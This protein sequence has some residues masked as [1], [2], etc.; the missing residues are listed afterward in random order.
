[1]NFLVSIS[2]IAFIL[3]F[4]A[5]DL[6]S[7]L[8]EN[9]TQ[10]PEILR[11]GNEQ[12]LSNYV[13]QNTENNIYYSPKY[14]HAKD[15]HGIDIVSW[16]KVSFNGAGQAPDPTDILQHNFKAHISYY[17]ENPLIPR[18]GKRKYKNKDSV[19]YKSYTNPATHEHEQ[20]FIS[21][22]ED[23]QVTWY[24]QEY[25]DEDFPEDA[26]TIDYDGL[27]D[28]ILITRK[29]IIA[30]VCRVRTMLKEDIEL[31]FHFSTE[32][33]PEEDLR[34]IDFVVTDLLS[35]LKPAEAP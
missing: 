29:T 9:E 28:H 20:L 24:K 4:K 2:I 10:Y 16:F 17:V 34:V 6:L 19:Y 1:M 22:L 33:L 18:T 13:F 25:D 12:S 8:N 7:E 31:D 23:R 30:T 15:S 35:H 14:A 27:Y 5:C 26:Y 3:L 21:G 11:I 32:N